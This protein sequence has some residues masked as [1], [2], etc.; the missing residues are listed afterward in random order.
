MVSFSE[1]PSRTSTQS[2]RALHHA[3]HRNFHGIIVLLLVS[4]DMPWAFRGW[5]G[6]VVCMHLR[7]L[8]GCQKVRHQLSLSYAPTSSLIRS[9]HA[10]KAGEAIYF[11]V[12]TTAML[13]SIYYFLEHNMD[14]LWSLVDTHFQIWSGIVG[15]CRI[16]FTTWPFYAPAIP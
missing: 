5:L 6:P 1:L 10:W 4:C 12:S 3:I 15:R 11:L 9:L 13:F 2:D 14:T 8:S 16:D 7:S